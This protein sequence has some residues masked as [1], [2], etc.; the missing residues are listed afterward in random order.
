MA[1]RH[2][3]FGHAERTNLQMEAK[4]REILTKPLPPD[5]AFIGGPWGYGLS[6]EKAAKLLRRWRRLLRIH[7]LTA[8]EIANN[9]VLWSK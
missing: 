5:G 6:G 4:V 7:G 8:G 1:K 2:K 3:R 9:M